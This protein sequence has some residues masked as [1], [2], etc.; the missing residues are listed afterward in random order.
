MLLDETKIYSCDPY[1]SWQG[2]QVENMHRLVRMFWP[3]G[4]SMNNLTQE[5]VKVIERK[6]NTYYRKRYNEY[7]NYRYRLINPEK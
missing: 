5:A 3:K 7:T 1:S 6:V 2:A 4:K